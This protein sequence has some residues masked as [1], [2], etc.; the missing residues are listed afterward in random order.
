MINSLKKIINK[1]F[2][3][4]RILLTL[5]SRIIF[6]NTISF[7]NN[8]K[9]YFHKLNFIKRPIYKALYNSRNSE[10]KDLGFKKIKYNLNNNLIK[11]I[12]AKFEQYI[13]DDSIC[14]FGTDKKSRHLYD[15]LKYIPEIKDLEILYK[16]EAK[17]FYSGEYKVHSSIAWRIYSDASYNKENK[18]YLYS[19]Y[20]HFDD[21]PKDLL[22]VFI[23]LSDNVNKNSGATRVIDVPTS[24]KL[25]RTFKFVDNALPSI[26]TPRVDKYVYRNDK[27]NYFEGNKG[28]VYICNTPRCLHAA[29]IP[30]EGKIRDLIQVELYPV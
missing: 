11:S 30:E 2:P 16:N 21:L 8:I 29:T 25:A 19:N 23:L 18:K 15:P 12:S 27:I 28:D 3:I 10:I 26:T 1:F 4:R 7:P 9:P 22:K 6:G 17:N 13:S 24:K 20:W 14:K 5:P